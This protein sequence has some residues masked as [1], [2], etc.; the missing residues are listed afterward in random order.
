MQKTGFIIPPGTT[1]HKQNITA[2]TLNSCRINNAGVGLLK[3]CTGVID[4]NYL[5]HF[6]P[7]S[8]S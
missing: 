2:L 6:S 3:S 5:I 7:I 4:C 8:N 1:V